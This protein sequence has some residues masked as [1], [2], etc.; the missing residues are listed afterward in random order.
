VL[1]SSECN[2]LVFGCCQLDSTHARCVFGYLHADVE[3]GSH[4]TQST[5]VR[6]C[7]REQIGRISGARLPPA[8]LMQPGYGEKPTKQDSR[9][10]SM[11]HKIWVRWKFLFDGH[12]IR[13]PYRYIYLLC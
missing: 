13:I 9:I 6:L 2:E 12:F 10:A 3:P 5:W 11:G 8:W 4:D 1:A 7:S